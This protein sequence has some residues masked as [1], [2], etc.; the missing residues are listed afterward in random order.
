FL[1]IAYKFRNRPFRFALTLTILM[2][3]YS[4][5]LPQ[6]IEGADRIFVTRNFFGVKKVLQSGNFRTLLHGDTT[7]G[8][9]NTTRP[10]T[11]TSYY[12]PSGTVG[13][14][15]NSMGRPLSRVGVLGLGTGTMA[16]YVAPERH[17]TFF[18]IDPQVEQ[19]ARSY[20]TYLKHCGENCSV[21]IGDGRLEL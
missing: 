20:F 19:I 21:I 17:I 16:G 4:I 2:I 1:V 14:I 10:A 13:Q 6:Y 3:A 7:H 9:E 12:H 5:T 8:V 18:D 11:P 15:M